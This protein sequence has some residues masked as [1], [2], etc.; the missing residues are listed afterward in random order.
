MKINYSPESINDLIRLRVFIGEK[1]PAAAK[2][3][4]SEI[5]AGID[6]LKIFPKMGLPVVRAPDPGIIRDLF[7]GQYTVRYPVS[8]KNIF[9]L[10]M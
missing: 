1:N 9:V 10:R 2:Q 6:K 7:I 4:A 8:S 5:L 3:I